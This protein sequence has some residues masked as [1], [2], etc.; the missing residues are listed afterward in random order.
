MN[1]TGVVGMTIRAHRTTNSA[2]AAISADVPDAGAEAFADADR[3]QEVGEGD[4][5]LG[6][7]TAVESRNGDG[8]R[9]SVGSS[10]WGTHWTPGV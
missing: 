2:P 7:G 10:C 4:A 6:G 5:A 8:H 9:G 1:G 3:D